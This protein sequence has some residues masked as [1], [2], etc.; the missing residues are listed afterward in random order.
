MNVE[1]IRSSC[2]EASTKYREYRAAMKRTGMKYL[3]ELRRAH[4]ELKRGHAI[5][6]IFAAFK[7]AGCNAQGDP[8]LAIAPADF[9]VID[10][11]KQ[12]LGAG[13][14]GHRSTRRAQIVFPPN[15]FLAWAQENNTWDMPRR[16]ISTR[17][18][19]VPAAHLPERPLEDFYLLWE[20]E[21]WDAVPADPYL[22]KR[23]NR[24]L[25]AVVASWDLTPLERA[26]I[27][28][29]LVN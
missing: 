8:R 21:R 28:G 3:D 17:V 5:V 18:P 19:I 9:K 11:R 24:N 7:Q 29:R 25:F 16:E 12:N 26:L 22:L 20:V 13:T 4:L 14:I 23:I 15:T 10:F 1:L 6:D 27:N 2:F